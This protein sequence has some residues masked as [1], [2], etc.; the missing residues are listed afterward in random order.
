MRYMSRNGTHRSKANLIANPMESR[1]DFYIPGRR[2]LQP[3]ENMQK[4]R[5]AAITHA[6]CKKWFYILAHTLLSPAIQ[7][8]IRIPDR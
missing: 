1:F 7:T 6:R 4:Y 8:R 2:N 5:N 3:A